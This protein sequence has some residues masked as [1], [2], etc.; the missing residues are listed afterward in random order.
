MTAWIN[1]HQAE[2]ISYVGDDGTGSDLQTGIV[3]LE[4]AARGPGV[5]LFVAALASGGGSDTNG[6]R[7]WE[8]P[9]ATM[10]AAFAA[11]GDN[12]RIY[13]IGTIA[14]QLLA[15]LGVQGVK[16]IGAAGGRT[17]HDDGARWTS[18]AE[19]N[20]T[21]PLLTLREQGWE[22]HNVLFVPPDDAPAI[23]FRR[24]E[25]AT[26]PDGS[27]AIVRN[28]KFVSDGETGIEDH[29]GGHHWLVEDCEFGS[30]D[31][32]LTNGIKHVSGAGIAAPRRCTIRRCTFTGVTNAIQLPG[33]ECVVKDN[34]F[35]AGTIIV[36]TAGG[37][38]KNFVVG[39]FFPAA[40]INNA[41]GYTTHAA[42]IVRN[43]NLDTAATTVG[44]ITT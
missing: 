21:T 18:P 11:A 17:R 8:A 6:G 9:F 40:T 35:G 13:F 29:G 38:G 30:A 4:R 23:R 24:A 2:S 25:S 22:V 19:P 34:L 10:A 44:A 37:S 27:H 16:V 7:S 5:D 26:Y 36:N 39:N 3:A 41:G 33:T 31:T 14:E 20:A 15:P 1:A 32:A 43:F 12:D 28:C 42:D